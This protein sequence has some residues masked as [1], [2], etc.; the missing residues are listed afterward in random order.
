MFIFKPF[1]AILLSITY[2]GIIHLLVRKEKKAI[3]YSISIFACLLQLSFLFLWIRKFLVLQTIHN[4]GFQ[5]F[6]KFAA[7][8]NGSYFVLFIPLLFLFAWYGIK[9]IMEQDQFLLLKKS[10]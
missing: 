4:E 10:S 5:R 6:E 8:V 9:K 7:F 2:I 1:Y 3:N